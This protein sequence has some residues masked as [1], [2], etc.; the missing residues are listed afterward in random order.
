MGLL[1]FAPWIMPQLTSAHQSPPLPM[2]VNSP[3]LPPEDPIVDERG[4]VLV[5]DNSLVAN[6]E[7]ADIAYKNWEKEKQ[8]PKPVVKPKTIQTAV[9]INTA[10]PKNG[11][12]FAPGQCTDYVARKIAIPWHGNAGAW[13]S[14]SKAYGAVVDKL[15][16]VGAILVTNESRAGHVAY[17]ES[18]NGDEF[19]ISEWNYQGRYKETTRTFNVTDSRIKGI[20]HYN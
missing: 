12:T 19:T 8:A 13:T 2:V 9:V 18:V 11:N 3:V 10:P 17:I 16:A 15:P 14:N 7:N 20:I 5:E 6:A 1:V 4:V